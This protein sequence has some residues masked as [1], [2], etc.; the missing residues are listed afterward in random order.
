MFDKWT[1]ACEVESGEK[2]DLCSANVKG[3]A[4]EKQ[5]SLK[6]NFSAVRILIGVLT[7]E[8]DCNPALGGA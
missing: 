1:N 6:L 3:F 4:W 2:R 7:S 5:M 8:P